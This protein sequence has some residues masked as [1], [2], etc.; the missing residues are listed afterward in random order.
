MG[1]ITNNLGKF[2]VADIGTAGLRHDFLFRDSAATRNRD[3][4]KRLAKNLKVSLR[5]VGPCDFLTYCGQDSTQ[6]LLPELA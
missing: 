6:I 1:N 2:V 3:E 5:S 4:E